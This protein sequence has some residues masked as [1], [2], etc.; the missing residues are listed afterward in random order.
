ML[1][2]DAGQGDLGVVVAEPDHYQSIAPKNENTLA[3]NTP[4]HAP[5]VVRLAAPLEPDPPPP[6]PDPNGFEPPEPPP[7]PPGRPE[8]VGNGPEVTVFEPGGAAG[9]VAPPVKRMN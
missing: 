1:I 9:C 6:P 2:P 3:T 7:F 4:V 5:G 8:S